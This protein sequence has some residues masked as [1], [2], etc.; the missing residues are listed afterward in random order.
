MGT[1]SEIER[2]TA[3]AART[4]GSAATAPGAPSPRARPPAVEALLQRATER[5][6]AAEERDARARAIAEELAADPGAYTVAEVAAFAA[7]DRAAAAADRDSAAEDRETLLRLVIG[8]GRGEG[9]PPGLTARES[10]VLERLARAMSTKA[11]ADDLYLSPNSVK[12]HTQ[13]VYRKI[14]VTS[15]AEAALW[16]RDHGIG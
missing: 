3:P 8:E 16:A 1:M 10:Q 9:P 6:V 13:S 5:D 2:D 12:T 15:R 11:I 14:G 7:A 4:N